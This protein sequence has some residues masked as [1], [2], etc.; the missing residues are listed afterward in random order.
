MS[1]GNSSELITLKEYDKLPYARIGETGVR[2]LEKLTEDLGIPLFHFS[3][4][5][6]Q[7]RQYVGVIRVGQRTIQILPKIY[8]WDKENL[9]YLVFLLGYTRRLR[10]RQAGTVGYAQLEGSFLEIWIRH[11]AIELRDLLRAQHKQRYVETEERL[12]FLR[13]K[14]L[15]ERELAGTGV[16][17]G[18]YACRYDLFTPD[19]LLNQALKF[20]NGL[21]LRQTRAAANRIILQEND[22]LLSEVTHRSIRASDLDRIHLDRLD[23]G[24]EPILNLCRLLLEHSTLDLRAGRITQLAF[25]FDMNRLFEEFVAEFLRRHIGR[26]KVRDQRWLADVKYQHRLGRLFGEFNMEADLILTDD[27][28]SRLLVDTKYKVLEAA[29]RHGGLAQEDFYQMYAYGK[30]GDRPYDEIVLLYPTTETVK[31]YFEHDG[32]QL[33]VRQF[34]PRAIYNPLHKRLDEPAAIEQLSSALQTKQKHS[35]AG[36]ADDA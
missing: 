32:L 16:L 18:R 13:G 10:L 25:V 36:G 9:G 21:L 19:H 15:V 28:G 17:T 20:C 8:D 33:Y 24:Y 23:R 5:E 22:A 4:T 7:A 30:A 6:A 26:I 29:K 12:G 34:D 27:T 11:F 1:D 3:R 31:A 35:Q 14:L 2:Q